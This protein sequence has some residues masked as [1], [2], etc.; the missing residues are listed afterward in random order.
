MGASATRGRAA[1]AG[2]PR[3]AT[4][5]AVTRP[6]CA[7]CD[8]PCVPLADYDVPVCIDCDDRMT[9]VLEVAGDVTRLAAGAPMPAAPEPTPTPLDDAPTLFDEL[10]EWAAGERKT[11]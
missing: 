2:S 3:S 11:A 8:R 1:R 5:R 4:G 6:P 9:T 10:R 7:I